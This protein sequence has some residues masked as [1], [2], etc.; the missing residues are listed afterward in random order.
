M[1]SR[2]TASLISN[3]RTVHLD[4][5]ADVIRPDAGS[6]AEQGSLDGVAAGGAGCSDEHRMTHSWI[7]PLAAL[8]HPDRH[9][10]DIG[11]PS[12]AVDGPCVS[13][14]SRICVSGPPVADHSKPARGVAVHR[15]HHKF[16]DRTGAPQSQ[17]A[18]LRRI[19]LFN[20][21]YYVREAKNL[22][23]RIRPDSRGSLGPDDL[24]GADGPHRHRAAL[25]RARVWPGLTS[26]SPMPRCTSRPRPDQR[27][28]HRQGHRISENTASPAPALVTG[29]SLHNT[30][31]RIRAPGKFS[32]RRPEFD[33]RGR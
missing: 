10:L 24:H 5:E 26:R 1:T 15:K 32:M 20:V 17:G 33:R 14:P 23:S 16:T 28:G 2:W 12:P 6:P 18:R 3:Y 21:Y 30:T 27:A 7:V 4:P 31:A 9:C 13:I 19:Q 29:E 22:R 25:S 11:L 8:T